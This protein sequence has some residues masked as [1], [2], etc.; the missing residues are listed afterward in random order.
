MNIIYL[1]G[2]KCESKIGVWE[3][4]KAVLQTLILDIDLA[5]DFTK[6]A[7]SDDL[8]HTLDYQA[9][10]ERVQAFAKESNF[11]LIETLVDRIA[12]LILDEFDTPWV[13]VK[14]DKGQAVKGVKNVGVVVERG[15][16]AQ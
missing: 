7:K 10:T 12:K 3:W 13:R 16:K 11:Q 6:V 5:A 1:H 8:T 4:E 14:L 15:I 9:I 2:L